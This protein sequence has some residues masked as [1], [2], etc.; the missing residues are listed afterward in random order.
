MPAID[1][2][3]LMAW[4]RLSRELAVRRE[5][6]MPQPDGSL[7]ASVESPSGDPTTATL[8]P[9]DIKASALSG[10]L[11]TSSDPA[12]LAYPGDVLEVTMPDGARRRFEVSPA[13]GD[14]PASA[15]EGIARF[16]A[17]SFPEGSWLSAVC[18]PAPE[19]GQPIPLLSR[20]SPDSPWGLGPLKPAKAAR[21]SPTMEGDLTGDLTGGRFRF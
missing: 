17:S 2:S 11:A 12:Y 14:T 18:L 20:A 21:S 4:T 1:A 15:R 13:E 8:T 6:I 3:R 9:D 10:H 16:L 7:I 5:D 19:G